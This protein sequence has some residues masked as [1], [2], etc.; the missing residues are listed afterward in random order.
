VA[1]SNK[2]L[3]TLLASGSVRTLSEISNANEE[4]VRQTISFALPTL[5]ESM[6][7]NSASLAGEMALSAALSSHADKDSSDV[8]SF[9][10]SANAEDGD[11]I[12]GHILGS[13]RSAV[14][15]RLSG[16]AGISVERVRKIL[17]A[18]APLVM[19]IIGSMQKKKKEEG[20]FGGLIEVLSSVMTGTKESSLGD[21][22]RGGFGS[23]FSSPKKAA[24]P[25]AAAPV[26]AHAAKPAAETK[27]AGKKAAESKPAA[28]K[29]PIKKIVATKP[30]PKKAPAKK[31]AA[32]KPAAKK[33]P[34]KKAPAKKPVAKKAPAKKASAKKPVA[35]KAV[36]KKPA[37][38]KAPAKKTT[39]KKPVAKKAIAKNPA[40]KKAP[41]KK[42]AAKKPAIKKTPAQKAP[43][44]KAAQKKQTVR[45]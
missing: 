37:A 12:I 34:A 11:K 33:A 23:L 8:A 6:K 45:I 1:Q 43:G 30:A 19:S 26:A 38:K 5:V 25:V 22:F 39:A 3:D 18:L 14:E 16:K 32:K 7:K 4:Q 10:R 42:A 44:K 28:G 35:K 40:A 36:A 21:L 24:A 31:A 13:D 15:S 17:T 9:I 2:L 27:P 41:A 20:S 29:A